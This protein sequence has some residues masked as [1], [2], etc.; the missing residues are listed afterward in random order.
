MSTSILSLQQ[1]QSIKPISENNAGKFNQL[2]VESINSDLVK[3]LGAPMVTAI[4]ASPTEERFV[5]LL[6]PYTFTNCYDNDVTHE[7]LRYV[8]AYLVYSRYIGSNSVKDTFSGMVRQNRSESE[9]AGYGHIKAMQEEAKAVAVA[10]FNIIK[11]FLIE[12]CEDY[13]EWE[14]G[15]NRVQFKPRMINVRKTYY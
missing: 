15:M 2:V 13:P 1:Q 7:G 12:N 10:Q 3:L 9:H 4:K 8:L 11:D 6:D 5:K 14:H